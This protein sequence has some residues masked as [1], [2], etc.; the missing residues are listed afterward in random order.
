MKFIYGIF[1]VLGILI[2]Y[3]F[4]FRHEFHQFSHHFKPFKLSNFGCLVRQ[5]LFLLEFTII[6]SYSPHGFFT[7]QLTFWKSIVAFSKI[8]NEYC[9][10]HLN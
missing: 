7:I 8:G 6:S 2:Q 3:H 10:L 5:L 4:R 1:L 9:Q